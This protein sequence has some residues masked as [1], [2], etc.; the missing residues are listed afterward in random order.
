MCCREAS[1]ESFGHL[2]DD[3]GFSR[4]SFKTPSNFENHINNFAD[5]LINDNW[6][7]GTIT[8]VTIAT[9]TVTGLFYKTINEY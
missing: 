5:S 7:H 2:F 4:I 6:N 3:N 8:T 9:V 1:S